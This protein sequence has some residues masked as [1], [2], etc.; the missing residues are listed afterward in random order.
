MARS[1]SLMEALQGLVRLVPELPAYARKRYTVLCAVRIDQP[2][3]RRMLAEHLRMTEREVRAES[4][5]LRAQGYVESTA[6]GMM[7]TAEGENLI[8]ELQNS[9]SA[10]LGL[11]NASKALEKALQVSQVIIAPVDIEQEPILFSELGHVAAVYLRGMLAGRMILAVTGGS[12]LA[13]VA[14]AMPAA[15]ESDLLVVP[16][17]G[18]MGGD[19][20]RQANT[21]AAKMAERLGGSY[22]LLHAPDEGLAAQVMEE[23]F[24][25]RSTMQVLKRA[26][27]LV[28]G[29]GRCDEMAAR[30]GMPG[31]QRRQLLE[32]G[33]VAEALGYYLDIHGRILFTA[34]MGGLSMQELGNIPLRIAVAGG[35][36][37]AEAILASCKALAPHVLVCDESAARGLLACCGLEGQTSL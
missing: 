24:H 33:G 6:A 29:I 16:S 14:Q 25:N 13:A 28:Y 20:A 26:D 35:N 8:R 18:G 12:T 36:K 31:I 27:V 21:I 9:I 34:G 32:A 11:E 10:L 5:F 17:R 37:K 3:G 19:I 22:R 1:I 23:S 30:R 2:V 7:L 4:E 15:H